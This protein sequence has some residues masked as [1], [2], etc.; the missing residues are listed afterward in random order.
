MGLFINS[1]RTGSGT[2]LVRIS[3]FQKFERVQVMDL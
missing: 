1:T 2:T 3:V